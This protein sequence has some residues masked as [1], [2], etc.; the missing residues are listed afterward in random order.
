MTV[1]VFFSLEIKKPLTEALHF[2]LCSAGFFDTPGKSIK[3][4]KATQGLSTN[5]IFFFNECFSLHNMQKGKYLKY[6]KQ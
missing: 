5:L 2:A 3:F 4:P 6:L 1:N